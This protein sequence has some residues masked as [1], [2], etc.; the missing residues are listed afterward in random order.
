MADHCFL[1]VTCR[2]EDRAKFEALGFH[3]EF[4][5]AEHNPLFP[6]S[7]TLICEEAP[8]GQWVELKK[9]AKDKVAFYVDQDKGEGELLPLVRVSDGVDSSVMPV[10]EYGGDPAIEVEEDGPADYDVEAARRFHRI[11]GNFMS[12]LLREKMPESADAILQSV[13]GPTFREQRRC[14]ITLANMGNHPDAP[15][16]GN[17]NLSDPGVLHDLN[18]L[19]SFLDDLADYAHDKLGK[20]CLLEEKEEG[21]ADSQDR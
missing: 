19:I 3:N 6:G 8:W 12:I 16:P 17:L 11:K 20:D 4:N 18:G 15:N 21:D 10:I 9:L 1:R 5:H 2:P 7:L 14:L 13:D